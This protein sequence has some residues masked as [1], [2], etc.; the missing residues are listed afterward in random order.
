MSSPIPECTNYFLTSFDIFIIKR[1][2]PKLS[3]VD[4]SSKWLIIQR[5]ET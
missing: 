5:K 4:G 1:L 2:L 3:R